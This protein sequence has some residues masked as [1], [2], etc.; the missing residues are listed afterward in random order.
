MNNLKEK[1]I[2][3]KL[4]NFYKKKIN[5]GNISEENK[6]KLLNFYKNK[7]NSGNI[8]E[9]NKKKLLENLKKTLN[10]EPNILKSMIAKMPKKNSEKEKMAR[11]KEMITN[12]RKES[13]QSNKII[14]NM[15]FYKKGQN[16]TNRKLKKQVIV[17]DFP[18]YYN[19]TNKIEKFKQNIMNKLE[20][21]GIPLTE[22][23]SEEKK[24]RVKE[25]IEQ[26]YESLP[27]IFKYN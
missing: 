16:I 14:N 11:I 25:I 26:K 9:E 3:Q 19:N 13:D 15:I 20:K 1:E 27:S 10:N 23:L 7:I 17:N 24:K 5:S 18:H 4:L 6:K 8:S 12:R 21:E 22:K 2:K